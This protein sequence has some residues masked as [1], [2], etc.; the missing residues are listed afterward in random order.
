M[1]L[2]F[3]AG[4]PRKFVTQIWACLLL[5]TI[6]DGA[7]LVILVLVDDNTAAMLA[8]TFQLNPGHWRA[9]RRGPW[10]SRCS[11]QLGNPLR[12]E[13]GASNRARS[14]RVSGW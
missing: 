1:C 5:L 11:P 7:E 3:G 4:T 10:L 6:A 2:L 12:N 13:P 9:R 14:C 8:R